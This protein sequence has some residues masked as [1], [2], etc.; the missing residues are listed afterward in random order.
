MAAQLPTLV[1]VGRPNVGKSTLFNRFAG[2]RIA[3]VQDQPGVTRDRLYAEFDHKDRK[4]RVVD[5]GGILFGDDDPLV[6]QIRVQAEV[7]LAEA[8][9][10]LFMVD[11]DEGLNPAD[12]D[13]A[14]RLRSIDVPVLVL[15]NKVDN[16]IREPQAAEFYALGFG[17]V[18]PV[19]GLHGRGLSDLMDK[20]VD[21]LP[22]T[23]NEVGEGDDEL[24]L[25]IIGRPNVGKSSMLN[26]FSGEERS[27]V[28]DI[29]GTTRDAIDSQVSWKGRKVRLIDTAG[30]RRRGKIQ[31]SIEYYMVLRAARA[32]ERAEC[33]LLVIDGNEGLTDGDKR[34][35]KASFELGKPLVIAVNKWD[36]V[37]P[38]DGNLGRTSPVKKEFV[39]S[40]KAEI[41]ECA[42]AIVRFTSAKMSTGMDGAINAAFS[43]VE[44]GNTRIPTGQ[45]NRLIQ[46]ATLD[47]PL[48]RKGRAFRVYYVTQPVSNP[49]TF[50]F[51]CNDPQLMHFSYERYLA[52]RIRAEFPMEG[53]PIRIFARKSGERE[54]ED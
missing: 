53:T 47:R 22:K 25:A 35:A 31:G 23:T 2:R 38:P 45:L 40:L 13:L 46:N 37:E 26:A 4:F 16:E 29:P 39:R 54:E 15:A 1:I 6:E 14:Q 24:R 28:S 7:A 49:P 30:I 17:E 36:Q 44:A 21:L 5:T 51:F 42:Y 50:I 43:A 18:F 9:V 27:I 12:E 3:V 41:P 52:N 32:L 48:S 8:S 19:S 10:I 11:A 34:V 33:A 20:V